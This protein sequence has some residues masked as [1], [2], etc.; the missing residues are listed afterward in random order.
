MLRQKTVF[1]FFNI[2]PQTKCGYAVLRTKPGE[3][4]NITAILNPISKNF[5]NKLLEHH[6]WNKYFEGCILGHF[7]RIFDKKSQNVPIRN[8]TIRG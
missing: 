7:F 2:F 8:I 5:H 1:C 4:R 6:I 3:G